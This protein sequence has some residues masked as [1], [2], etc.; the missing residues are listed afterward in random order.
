M[1]TTVSPKASETPRRPIPT[2]GNA[3]GR[4]ALPHPPRTNQNV[5]MNSAP[6]F[7][8]SGMSTPVIFCRFYVLPIALWESRGQKYQNRRPKLNLKDGFQHLLRIPRH[9]RAL[10]LGRIC[11]PPHDS[12]GAFNGAT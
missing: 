8:K 11:W 6:S 10:G 12:V 3:A 7:L 4:T 1:V 5:P 2:W 9:V